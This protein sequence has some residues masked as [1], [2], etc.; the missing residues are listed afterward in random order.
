MFV[1][2]LREM[3]GCGEIGKRVSELFLNHDKMLKTNT[4]VM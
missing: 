4:G 3:L 2:K 1:F